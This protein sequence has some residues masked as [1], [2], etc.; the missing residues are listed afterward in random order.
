ML[1]DNTSHAYTY[2]YTHKKNKG[3]RGDVKHTALV[4]M[5]AIKIKTVN[6][7]NIKV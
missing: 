2:R 3:K 5:E 1:I 4:Q 6:K 7:N